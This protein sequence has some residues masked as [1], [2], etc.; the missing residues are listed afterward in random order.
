MGTLVEDFL[1][2]DDYS[3]AT[4]ISYRRILEKLIQ[5]EDVA[6]FTASDLLNFVKNNV[7][8]NEQQNT[9]RYVALCAC[10]S[11]ISWRYGQIH[12]ALSAR[13]KRVHPKRQRAL[14]Y[15]QLVELLASFDT[16]TAIGA[17]DLAIVAIAIDTGLR[18]A[19]LARLKFAD[20]DL[21]H[22]KLQVIVKGG[23][24]GTGIFSQQTAFYIEAWL[25]FRNPAPG[26]D[27]LFVS[28][29]DNKDQGKELTGH[30]I[31]MIFRKWSKRL[32]FPFSPHDARRTFATV[33][34]LL[35]APSKTLM[36]AG[37]WSNLE[38]V[39]RY[40][41]NIAEDA[42]RPYLPL[43]NIAKIKKPNP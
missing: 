16:S 27:T 13:I 17:R 35:G 6:A 9:Q 21:E 1:A 5:V 29:R 30:G 12:P 24:W 7:N 14:S 25:T 34:T 23:Q 2:S 43:A 42:I 3:E 10:R 18:R 32:G 26:V 39:D 8:G 33:A 11:F 41:K 37:R 22:L 4:K 19:E 36:V 31:K 15:E 40:T 38:M 20:I 28:L